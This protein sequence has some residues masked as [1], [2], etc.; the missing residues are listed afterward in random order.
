MKKE[1]VDNSLPGQIPHCRILVDIVDPDK[2]RGRS[3]YHRVN[4]LGAKAPLNY[5][6]IFLSVGGNT[7]I[8]MQEMI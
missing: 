2:A 8:D 5:I 7:V 1:K 6:N 3:L 4:L